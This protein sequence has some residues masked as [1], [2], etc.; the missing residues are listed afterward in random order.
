MVHHRS[1]T[2]HNRTLVD[3]VTSLGRIIPL[4]EQDLE[5]APELLQRDPEITE[6]DKSETLE[7]TPVVNTRPCFVNLRWLDQQDI[8]KWHIQKVPTALP[9]KTD[10]PTEVSASDVLKT[11][12]IIEHHQTTDLKMITHKGK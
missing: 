2:H 3:Y 12:C 10:N 5:I 9:D 6:K 7:N 8:T 11:E 1:V 4:P